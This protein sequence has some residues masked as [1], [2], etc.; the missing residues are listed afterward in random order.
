VSLEGDTTDDVET[1]VERALLGAR[2]AG[3]LPSPQAPV[4]AA[5]LK[6]TLPQH[7]A[8]CFD[9]AAIEAF[10]DQLLRLPE[11]D[12][13]SRFVALLE[14]GYP[15]S[16]LFGELLAGAAAA[17]GERWERDLCSF[18]EVTLG[19][20]AVHRLLH[21]YG[22]VLSGDVPPVA[23]KPVV[24]VTPLPGETHIFASALLSEYFR[25]ARWRV[26]SGIQAKYSTV[27]SHVADYH[28]DLVAI[29]LSSREK[30]DDLDKLINHMRL[31]S[32]TRDLQVI[33]GG[34][35]FVADP[36]LHKVVGAD[37]TAATAEEALE[38]SRDLLIV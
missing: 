3:F 29:T 4:K 32:R 27:I 23:N 24:L 5:V 13:D 21:R 28:I 14:V 6:Q 30:A 1:S 17:L 16:R 8:L 19:M 2:S 12:L 22:D 10:T 25:A 7:S 37:A 18:A 33:V 31:R 11:P 26:L 34:A 9:G 36:K 38:V 35:P 15:P 20:A